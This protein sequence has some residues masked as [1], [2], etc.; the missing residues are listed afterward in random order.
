MSA[1][2][3]AL[4]AGSLLA[5]SRAASAQ[6]HPVRALLANAVLGIAALSLI[7]L[8]AEYTQ[9]TLPLNWFSAFVSVVLGA[10]GV[11]LLLLVR[12]WI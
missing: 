7:D 10:P 6:K 2:W 4:G 1:A 3:W 12:L 5:V 8:A 9:V 11:L